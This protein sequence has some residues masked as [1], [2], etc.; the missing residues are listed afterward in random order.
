MKQQV[1]VQAAQSCHRFVAQPFFAPVTIALLALA[2][3]LHGL[4]DKPLWLDEVATLHRASMSFGAMV[5]D[6]L[7][8]KHYPTYFALVWLVAKLGVAPGLLRLPSAIFGA[9]GAG[10]VS[11]VGTEAD[12]PRTGIAAGLLMALSPFDVQYGQEARSYT[13][14]AALILIA[15]WGLL[16]LSRY[17]S[18]SLPAPQKPER[19]AWLAYGGGTLAALYVLNVAVPWL[20]ASNIAALAIGLR[21]TA[22]RAAFLWRWSLVQAAILALWL[23]ALGA[24]LYDSHGAALEGPGWALPEKWAMLW[25]IFGPVYLYRISAF[26]TFDVLPAPVPGLALIILALAIFGIWRLRR[27]PHALIVIGC[28]ACALPLLLLLVSRVTPVLVPRYFAWSAAPFFVLV[29]AGIPNLTRRR[30]A[31][32]IATF[33]IAAIINLEPYYTA[34]TKPRWDLAAARLAAETQPGDVVLF[35]SW[36]A[37]YVATAGAAEQGLDRRGLTMVWKIADAAR[38]EPGHALWVV[39]GRTGQGTMQRPEDYAALLAPL[40]RAT[41]GEQVGRY[42]RIWR[43]AVPD[44]MASACIGSN[45]CPSGKGVSGND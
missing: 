41:A 33:V 37:Y 8:S 21:A 39:F 15:L 10:L 25:S 20:I 2:P 36:D 44:A 35:N 22:R 27:A 26:I 23:P 1:L 9:L 29:G 18:A 16:R 38:F 6:S 11:I 34:E 13:L 31:V 24:V 3:R 14:V 19:A 5:A 12:Q 40:G 17:G 42:I 30:Y 32:V 4:A 45:A 7:H 43:F 28:A